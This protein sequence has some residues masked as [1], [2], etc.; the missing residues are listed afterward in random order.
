MENF[1][2]DKG[3]MTKD[4]GGRTLDFR[5]VGRGVPPSRDGSP[6]GLAPPC[7][8]LGERALNAKNIS[9]TK[10]RGQIAKTLPSAPRR[11]RRKDKTKKD[12]TGRVLPVNLTDCRLLLNDQHKSALVDFAA[13][14]AV[15]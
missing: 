1:Y 4:K 3:Q 8:P 10:T 2:K 5:L 7:G 6:G 14:A 11:D 12:A 9:P 13:R 15:R